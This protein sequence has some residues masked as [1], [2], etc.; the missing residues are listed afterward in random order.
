MR[1]NL[2]F[3]G[4]TGLVIGIGAAASQ[5]F[6]KVQP[7]VAYG[8]CMVCHPGIMV[9]WVMNNYFGTQ[10][11]I[12]QVFVLFPSLL[13]I[14]LV[15]G[16][17]AAADRNKEIAWQSTTARKKY[18]SAL[19]GFLVA[20][21]GL[22]VGACPVRAALLVSYGSVTGVVEVAFIVMGIGLACV[23]LRRRKETAI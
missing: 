17:F 3:A 10:L 16:A 1:M 18:T 4:L 13:V 7:P 15:I 11:A 23:Y 20:I 14:G 5:A 9:K 19:F 8:Y 6:F 22:I 12:S 21:S 2:W